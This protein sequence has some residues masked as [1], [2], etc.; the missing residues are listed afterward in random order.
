LI[1]GGG[2]GGVLSP[3]LLKCFKDRKIELKKIKN[4]NKIEIK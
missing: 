4:R 2:G 3:R 1:G